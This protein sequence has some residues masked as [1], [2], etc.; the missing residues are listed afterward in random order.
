MRRAILGFLLVTTLILTGADVRAESGE[1]RVGTIK[2]KPARW[3]D[4]F[5]PELAGRPGS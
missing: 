1:L 5:V 4:V 3:S 2:Q